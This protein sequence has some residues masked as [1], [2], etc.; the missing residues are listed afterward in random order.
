MKSYAII[1]TSG[2]LAIVLPG[3]LACW[4]GAGL[5]T[6]LA[7]AVIQMLA[8][9]LLWVSLPVSM[10]LFFKFILSRQWRNVG[11]SALAMLAPVL[12]WV[13]IAL[14]NKPGMDAVMSA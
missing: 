2:A 12:S 9:L 1:V 7:I 10:F 13:L 4:I 14:T 6:L 3:A 5:N 8:N 11:W